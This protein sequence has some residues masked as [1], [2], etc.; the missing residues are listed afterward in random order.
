MCGALVVY[1]NDI[2]GLRA[3]AVLT[4]VAFHFDLR[5]IAPGGFVGVD[6]FFVISGFLITKI[7]YDD[8][9]SNKYSVID[10]Y[11]R[12]MRRIFPALFLIFVCCIAA[13][14]FL[15]LQSLAT[16]TARSLTSSALFV[17]NILFY[18]TYGYFDEAA[19]LNPLLH[20]WSL[21]VEEQFY[22]LFPIFVFAVR[23][24]PPIVRTASILT[25]T[26]GS[27]LYSAWLVKTDISGAFY[28]V[29]SRAWELMV[30]ALLA[31][32]TLPPIADLRIAEIVAVVG[33]G[34]IAGSVLFL[35]DTI[36]FPGFA[37]V[38][39]CAGAA[40]II[41]S[42]SSTRTKVSQILGSWPFRF[43][44]LISYSLYLWHWP[45][46]VFYKY[47]REPNRVEKLGLV[48]FCI[49]MAALTWQFVERPF[50]RKPHLLGS[51]ATL[52]MGG[53][54]MIAVSVVTTIGATVPFE[55]S[56]RDMLV[57][58]MI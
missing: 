5:T 41:Y 7:I 28:L 54:L 6:V 37:A 40:S 38:P 49:V 21:S 29:Q 25:I 48:A 32:S 24:L 33:L 3:I 22:V 34:L 58:F 43:I 27:L 47:F 16:L 18:K 1:R 4:V 35:H 42:S 44:G 2:D 55:S 46:I 15:R 53:L 14:Y 31:N 26:A 20:T 23:R 9:S 30:G 45:V 39:A 13:T 8:I 10:F 51:K 57:D 17:S 50:R 11:D 56:R 12:R 52:C 36:A 19:A